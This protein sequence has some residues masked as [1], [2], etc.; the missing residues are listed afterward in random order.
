MGS[1]LAL[2]ALLWLVFCSLSWTGTSNK[3]ELTGLI[4]LKPFG[5]EPV[6]FDLQRTRGSMQRNQNHNLSL[7]YAIIA[8]FFTL[9]IL[10]SSDEALLCPAGLDPPDQ[11]LWQSRSS[12][13]S[14]GGGGGA[15]S[16]WL[17]PASRP[18]TSEDPC[19]R[20]V[21][22]RILPPGKGSGQSDDCIKRTELP[23]AAATASSSLP[24]TCSS[25]IVYIS[26]TSLT[27]SLSLI[28]CRSASP[29][30]TAAC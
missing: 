14:Q 26:V 21:N 20:S 10:H 12:E 17:L 6:C 19:P 28:F 4:Y 25:S 8:V 1:S 22:H 3:T 27:S 23:S 18:H 16:A 11:K 2:L 13:R 7:F 24:P 9:N 29:S 5:L 30:V 15:S